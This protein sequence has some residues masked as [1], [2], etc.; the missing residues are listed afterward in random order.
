[1]SEGI[2]FQVRKTEPFSGWSV[3]TYMI[4]GQMMNETFEDRKLRTLN[5]GLRS[6]RGLV[7]NDMKSEIV[8]RC[9]NGPSGPPDPQ[10]PDGA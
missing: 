7:I 10:L 8:T 2:A 1:M 3:I 5:G 4:Y 9:G 6:L